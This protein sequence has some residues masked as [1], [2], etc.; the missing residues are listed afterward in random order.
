MPVQL[1]PSQ[2]ALLLDE[3]YGRAGQGWPSELRHWQLTDDLGCHPEVQTAAWALWATKLELTGRDLGEPGGWLNY[4][5]SEI[6][7]GN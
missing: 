4:N 2:I 5:F 3:V 7:P 1:T 6:A